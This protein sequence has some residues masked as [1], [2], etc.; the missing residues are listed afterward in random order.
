MIINVAPADA[1]KEAPSPAEPSILC[2]CHQSMPPNFSSARKDYVSRLESMPFQPTGSV[3]T[4]ARH[5]VMHNLI[6]AEMGRIH[7]SNA[8]FLIVVFMELTAKGTS[9]NEA[10][11]FRYEFAEGRVCP[12]FRSA[13]LFAGT[14]V[15]HRVAKP[16]RI[17][18]SKASVCRESSSIASNSSTI[19]AIG[20]YSSTS[21]VWM[22]LLGEIL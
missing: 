17:V 2:L 8:V 20:R 15:L 5:F 11:G 4:D 12:T 13:R 22:Y 6:A 19:S 10:I 21:P 16:F 3:W 18:F 1:N 7:N 9:L 14:V